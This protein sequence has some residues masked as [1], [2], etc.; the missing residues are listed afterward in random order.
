MADEAATGQTPVGSMFSL[1]WL[2][3]QLFG[4]LQ[5]RQTRGNSNHLPTVNELGADKYMPIAFLELDKLLAPYPDLSDADIKTAW[6]SPGHQGCT[7]AVADLHLKILDKLVLDPPQLSAYQLGRALSDTCWL[8]DKD[9]GAEFVLQQF[10]RHRL[11][12]LDAW[13]TGASSALPD[14][15]AATM[16]RSLQN[17]QDWVDIN[18]KKISNGWDNAYRSVV[19]ALRTQAS[20]WHALLAS[21][22]DNNAQPGIDAWVFA[23]QSI[24]RTTRVLMLTILR[25]FWLLVVIIA[26]ATGGLLYLAIANASG[27]EKVWTSLVTVAAAVGVTG[28]SLRAAATKAS[29]TLEADIRAAATLD[30]RAWAVTW[31]P[32]LP[33]SR[34]QQYRLANRG[35]AVPQAATNR[36]TAASSGS[37]APTS[38]P[39]PAPAPVTGG[40][41]V[42]GGGLGEGV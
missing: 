16:S 26:A 15:S 14:Q 6:N 24:L 33:Q 40:G 32:T 28:T 39:A 5:H 29:G 25:R 37:A 34:L 13:L 3:A 1:G 11:A 30:A 17:W 2:M 9:S 20:A 27:T 41:G 12:T 4:P 31:L 10:E 42:G 7:D 18:A 21:E 38:A 8:P 23:G 35:V 36:E 19:A 22:T